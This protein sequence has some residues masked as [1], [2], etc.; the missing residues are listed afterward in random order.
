MKAMDRYSTDRSMYYDREGK[1]IS[2]YEWAEKFNDQSYKRIGYTELPWGGRVSTVWLGL[3]HGFGEVGPLI[4]ETMVFPKDS[5]SELDCQR[6]STEDQARAGH[7]A[8]VEKWQSKD[9]D[10]N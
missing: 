1:P 10:D 8:M 3:D 7:D 5:F 2:M 9:S 4:F 6:Y